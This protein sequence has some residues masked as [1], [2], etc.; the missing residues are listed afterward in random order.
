[1]LQSGRCCGWWPQIQGWS[2]R[3]RILVVTSSG[4]SWGTA[5][6]E[7]S[8]QVIFSLARSWQG[9]GHL[10]SSMIVRSFGHTCG[11]N[12]SRSF[13]VASG[14]PDGSKTAPDRADELLW[15]MRACVARLLVWRRGFAQHSVFATYVARTGAHARITAGA[16]HFGLELLQIWRA[17]W[18]CAQE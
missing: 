15:L 6:G 17:A 1:M 4:V 16:D 14:R 12:R 18:C 7:Y 2:L 11:K 13:A 5:A 3:L 9:G 8:L 10:L